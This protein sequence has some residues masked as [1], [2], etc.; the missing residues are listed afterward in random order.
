MT[1]SA[2]VRRR[3]TTALIQQASAAWAPG[4]FT[5]A[6]APASLLA[7]GRIVGLG[8]VGGERLRGFSAQFVATLA[9]AAFSVRV[10]GVRYLLSPDDPTQAWKELELIELLT[11]ALTVTPGTATGPASGVVVAASEE[12]AHTISAP[13]ASAWL[14]ARLNGYGTEIPFVFSPGS[15]GVAELVVP[16]AANCD[17]YAFDIF[18]TDGQGATAVTR[19]ES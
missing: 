15:N 8:R 1:I 9:Q 18:G 19:G 14:L 7:P 11:G 16:D 6:T 3:Y 5:R 2:S 12:F 17:G 4:F 10:Y 13:T